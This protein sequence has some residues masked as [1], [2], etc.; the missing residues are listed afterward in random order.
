MVAVSQS[1]E[2]AETVRLLEANRRASAVIAVTN[3][4]GS[5]LA[6]EADAVLLTRAGSEFSVSCKTYVATLMMLRW[7]GDALCGDPTEESREKLA[8]SVGR[9]SAYLTGWRQHAAALAARLEKITDLFMVGRG[10]SLAAV[11]AG[12]LIT[13]ESAHFH[14]EGMSSAA[15][16][17]G[18]FEMLSGKIFVAVFSGSEK[19]RSLNQRLCR[20]IQ[21]SG[22]NAEMIG[23]DSSF[24]C[25]RLPDHDD[26]IRPILEI[27]PIQMMTI[28]LAALG[29]REAGKFERAAK[30]TTVE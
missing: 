5:T 17:H 15:F 13:K 21:E 2:S 25:F 24:A 11:S 3:T 4:P 29:G 18:P 20:D 6:R 10:S 22:G 7:L 19:T 28:A 26:S 14:A 30:I 23:E 9:V 8:S 12:A 27:L 16:R 1:G